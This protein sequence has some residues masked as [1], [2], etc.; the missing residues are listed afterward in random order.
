[1]TTDML[2]TETVKLVA[3][4]MF[5]NE[6]QDLTLFLIRNWTLSTIEGG[7]V[8]MPVLS[9]EDLTG[10]LGGKKTP[11]KIQTFRKKLPKSEANPSSVI[12]CSPGDV[13]VSIEERTKPDKELKQKLNEEEK[14][15]EQLK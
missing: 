10:G 3:N 7:G 13:M 6:S 14:T 11:I 1:M 12:L 2:D 4:K 8:R 5:M 15:K 9:K